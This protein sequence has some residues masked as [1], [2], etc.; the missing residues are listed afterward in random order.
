MISSFFLLLSFLTAFANATTCADGWESPSSGSGTCSH[1]GG[2]SAGA[3]VPAGLPF[4]S[5]WN[6]S[7]GVT[8]SGAVYFSITQNNPSIIAS[9]DCY[10]YESVGWSFNIALFSSSGGA[11]VPAFDHR[12][13]SADGTTSLDVFVRKGDMIERIVSWDVWSSGGTTGLGGPLYLQ[14]NKN[15]GSPNQAAGVQYLTEED[16][17]KI[18]NADSLHVMVYVGEIVTS[19]LNNYLV[20]TSKLRTMLP[21]MKKQCASAS[22][23][24]A[25]NFPTK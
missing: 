23:L 9:L 22:S 10:G 16:L 12:H 21:A 20:D 18:E 7:T 17:A 1:H 5:G 2:V 19:N 3:T 14:K 6:Y 25:K 24:A 13:D 11:L 15:V 8:N 4:S